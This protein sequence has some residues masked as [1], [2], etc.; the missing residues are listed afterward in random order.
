MNAFK[1]L[2]Y[3]VKKMQKKYPI[4]INDIFGGTVLNAIPNSANVSFNTN[5]T[6]NFLKKIINKCNSSLLKKYPKERHY[7][8]F[9][10]SVKL[11]KVIN[12]KQNLQIINFF[13][14]VFNGVKTFNKKF[15]LP[16][17][18]SNL[19]KAFI[20]NSMLYIGF[21][22]RDLNIESKLETNK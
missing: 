18:S 5:A 17:A 10:S 20:K 6:K 9:L 14:N 21:N 13:N 22:G 11:T 4:L 15:H 7:K 12:E 2:F 3:I 16:Q 8:I 1:G 19:G